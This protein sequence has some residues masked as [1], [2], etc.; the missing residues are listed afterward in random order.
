[1]DVIY[2]Y[3]YLFYIRIIKDN[4]PHMLTILAISATEGFIINIIIQVISIIY[5]C[6]QTS[7]LIW[8]SIIGLA[9]M[10]NYLYYYKSG[11]AI[12]IIK[13]KPM[14]YSSNRISILS[15]ISFFIVFG[16]SIIWGSILTKYLL[17]TYCG[18]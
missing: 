18:K 1:M 14:F 12:R 15:T 16:T 5:Q 4:E 17:E 9:N 10:F 13:E 8:M 7:N 6:K 3:F 2:Y 11:R